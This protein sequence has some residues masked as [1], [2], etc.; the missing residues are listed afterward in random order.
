MAYLLA[1]DTVNGA[2]GK[3]FIYLLYSSSIEKRV[4]V[5]ECRK[6]LLEYLVFAAGRNKFERQ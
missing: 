4:Y 2:E 6:E 1:K 5:L 3:I